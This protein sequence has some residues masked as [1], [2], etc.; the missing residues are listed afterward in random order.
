MVL[1]MHTGH[2]EGW[3]LFDVD[4]SGLLE[5]QR[6]DEA[7][8]FGSDEEAVGF[9]RALASAGSAMHVAALAQHDQHREALTK[10]R[11]A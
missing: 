8:V 11:S 10:H 6:L 7:E 3:G 5:I 1:A 9:V 2:A 4:A